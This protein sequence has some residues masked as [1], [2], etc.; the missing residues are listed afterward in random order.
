MCPAILIVMCLLAIYIYIDRYVFVYMQL[1]WPARYYK[2]WW[3]CAE[4]VI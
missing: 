3:L 4:L 1:G 2:I